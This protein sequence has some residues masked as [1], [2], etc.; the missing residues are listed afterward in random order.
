MTIEIQQIVYSPESVK[1]ILSD[2]VFYAFNALLSIIY[3]LC[4]S[5]S[6]N[7]IKYRELPFVDS[8]LYQ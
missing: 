4:G 2:V 5:L 6:Q 3:S 7:D 8:V 1:V